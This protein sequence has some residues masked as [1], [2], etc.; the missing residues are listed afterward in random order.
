MAPQT[1]PPI[2]IPADYL[3]L[4]SDHGIDGTTA[5]P[6]YAYDAIRSHD[7]VD[8]RQYPVL[9]WALIETEPGKYDWRAVDQWM[10][11]NEGKT[12]IFVLF[13]CPRF[14]QKYPDEAW[15][16][17]YLP[18]GGSP[19]K[20]PADAA[21]FISALLERHP[22]INFV[23]IWNEPNFHW[24]SDDM[25]KA[26]WLPTYDKPGFYTGTAS[27][28]AG[29]ARAVARILPQSTR[30]MM[31]AWEGQDKSDSMTSSLLRL[32]AAPDGAGGTG[33]QHAHA[34]SVHSYTYDNKPNKLIAEL[35]NY[36]E[37]FAQAGYP[38]SMPRYLSEIGAEAP[39]LWAADY[40]SMT[41]KIRNIKRWCM[42]PAALGYR[43]VY[44]YKH[45]KM[46]TLGD[47]AK[48]PE[49]AS[50]IDEMRNGLRNKRLRA[51]AELRDDSIWLQ[52]EDGSTLRG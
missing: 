27:E 14:Y 43:G 23:E 13:G 6:T 7:T 32:A 8:R 47:P 26:R 18:G 41:T 37:R 36:N 30:L 28:L 40:P 45:S 38:A 1:D 10:A 44:L 16:Y 49:L 46:R 34:L 15:R 4:H 11:A 52:F 17:P 24:S 20:D 51:A 25:L 19:P 2:D 21:R 31:G 12:S 42:I 50:A 9:Q 29:L 33:K 35:Q 22:G 3:G 48:F 39:G 5:A